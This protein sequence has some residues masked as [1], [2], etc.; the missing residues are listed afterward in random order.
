ML[1]FNIV[2]IWRIFSAK[3]ANAQS[4]WFYGRLLITRVEKYNG[5]DSALKG[6]LKIRGN[7]Q[8]I[9]GAINSLDKAMQFCLTC[10]LLKGLLPIIFMAYWVCPIY[11]ALKI[12]QLIRFTR[13]ADFVS[14]WSFIFGNI[15][16]LE[17]N[18]IGTA[19]MK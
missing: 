1:N 10:P 12:E 13:V 18:F 9:N 3:V 5:Q 11:L 16:F 17:F 8:R 15:R 19:S 4:Y 2:D 14:F 6:P 7:P